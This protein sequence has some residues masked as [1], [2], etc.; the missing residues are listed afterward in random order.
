[1]C[2]RHSVKAKVC[3][4]S[5]KSTPT[6]ASWPRNASSPSLALSFLPGHPIPL[7]LLNYIDH[8][9]LMFCSA[10]PQPFN[11]ILTILLKNRPVSWLHSLI[12]AG[13]E[14]LS[15]KVTITVSMLHQN[16]SVSHSSNNSTW[17]FWVQWFFW[18]IIFQVMSQI[19]FPSMAPLSPKVREYY[20]ISC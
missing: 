3:F 9:T 12:Q 2:G 19:L 17:A 20:A 11:Q 15:G 8:Q 6:E 4:N 16:K 1:M 7:L 13:S 14:H 5:Q 10:S 18:A